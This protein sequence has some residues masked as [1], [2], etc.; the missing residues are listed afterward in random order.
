MPVPLG[1]VCLGLLYTCHVY[2]V[3]AHVCFLTKGVK[4]C[5]LNDLCTCECEPANMYFLYTCIF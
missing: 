3:F 4:L 5:G 2:A 1:R